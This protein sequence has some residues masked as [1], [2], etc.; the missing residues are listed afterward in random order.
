MLYYLLLLAAEICRYVIQNI[1]IYPLC[2]WSCAP[3]LLGIV[4]PRYSV[5]TECSLGI[6]NIKIKDSKR[7]WIDYSRL[8]TLANIL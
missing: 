4:F 7:A 3:S 5:K 6:K 2:H 8:N 1:S